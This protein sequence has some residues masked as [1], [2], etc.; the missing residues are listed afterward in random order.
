MAN[1]TNASW[2]ETG[3]AVVLSI[4]ANHSVGATTRGGK[5][6][7]TNKRLVF[8]PHALDRGLGASSVSIPL[9][10]IKDVGKEAAG[11]SPLKIFSGG[12]RSRLRIETVE[13]KVYL[14]VV[15]G[16]ERVVAQIRVVSL[17]S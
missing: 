10:Q 15:N 13:G 12:I 3:E 7:L 16:L 2:L 6:W 11:C 8:A 14:F 9:S 17:N 5:L 4:A 1:N